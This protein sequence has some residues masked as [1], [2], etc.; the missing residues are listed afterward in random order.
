MRFNRE[1][2]ACTRIAVAGAFHNGRSPNVMKGKIALC[3]PKTPTP[4]LQVSRQYE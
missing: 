3:M 1:H 2:S 4:P